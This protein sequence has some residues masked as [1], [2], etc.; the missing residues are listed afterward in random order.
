MPVDKKPAAV[1]VAAG[2]NACP[3]C[4]A[5]NEPGSLMCKR[6]GEIL[7]SKGKRTPTQE[8]D[9]T[10]GG[11]HPGCWVAIAVMML[12]AILF[13]FLAVR[14][15]AKPGTCEYNQGHIG[16][17]VV[18]YNKAHPDMKMTTLDLAEL[19]K[20]GKS[21]KPLLKETPVC[22]VDSSAR[23]ELD[24]DGVTVICTSCSK[25]RKR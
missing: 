12:G 9:G 8:Y 21:G 7:S 16:M 22:P 3:S 24:A 6:C 1:V 18:R 20:P 19:Q 15:G 23:Y 17:A 13:F 11:F 2:P 14:G 5:Q 25:K 10:E 4:R